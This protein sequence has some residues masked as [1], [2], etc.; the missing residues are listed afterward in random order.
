MSATLISKAFGSFMFYWLFC[1]IGQAAEFVKVD[2]L[3]FY[4]GKKRF[5]SAGVNCVLIK[6]GESKNDPK[7]YDV[8]SLGTDGWKSQIKERFGQW[9]FNTIGSY[10]AKELETDFYYTVSLHMGNYTKKGWHQLMDV[11]DPEYE[12]LMEVFALERC[13]PRKN[14]TNLLGYFVSNEIQWFGDLPWGPHSNSLLKRYQALPESAPGRRAVDVFEKEA[15]R[16]GLPDHRWEDVW[17]GIVAEE[18]MRTC[19]HVIRKHD[20]NHLILGVRFAALPPDEVVRSVSLFSD[21]LSFNLYNNDFSKLDHYY[22]ITGK[23][24]MVT[25]FSWRAKENRTGNLNRFGP[26]VDVQ[27][28]EDRANNYRKYLDKIMAR[29]YVIGIQ[30]FQYFDQPAFGRNDGED[31]NFGLVDINDKPYEELTEQA[32]QS[33]A[34]WHQLLRE[35]E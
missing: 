29:P 26:W 32:S 11:F 28:Q 34:R 14:D 22:Y 25:E 5:Y 30:W 27:T 23:P 4:Q 9:G 12:K 24:L 33:N 17:A 6:D 8:S 1:L 7:V 31:S 21:V 35:R 10:S 13:A 16:V 19:T 2:S 3:S 18:Y 20:P 15:K